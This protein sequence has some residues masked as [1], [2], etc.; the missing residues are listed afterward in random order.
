M[1]VPIIFVNFV[2]TKEELMR[3]MQWNFDS[4]GLSCLDR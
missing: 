4:F 2:N 1:H 3:Y